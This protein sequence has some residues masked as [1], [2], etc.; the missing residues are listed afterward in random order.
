MQHYADS[1]QHR[2]VELLDAEEDRYDGIIVNASSLP[3]DPATFAAAL[4]RSLQVSLCQAQHHV[5]VTNAIRQPAL[6][7]H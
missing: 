5:T 7:Q 4:K 3:R 2:N 6:D 1:M